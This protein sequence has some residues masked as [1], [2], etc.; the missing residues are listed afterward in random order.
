MGQAKRIRDMIYSSNEVK[1]RTHQSPHML[2][3]P[4]QCTWTAQKPCCTLFVICMG[5]GILQ[6]LAYHYL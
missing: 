2:Y 3:F 4:K 5:T 1:P 6:N